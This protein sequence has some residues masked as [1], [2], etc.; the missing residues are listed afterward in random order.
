MRRADS[1]HQAASLHKEELHQEGVP[2]AS[3]SRAAGLWVLL[4]AESM[5]ML[6]FLLIIPKAA[7]LLRAGNGSHQ[8]RVAGCHLNVSSNPG[9]FQEGLT[10]HA[11]MGPRVTSP[12]RL[13]ICPEK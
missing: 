8:Q 12:A 9:N 2:L 7:S 6:V 3:P 1:E 4:W 10:A 5:G 11:V 13:F